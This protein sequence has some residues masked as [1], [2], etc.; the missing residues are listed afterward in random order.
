[1]KVYL[2]SNKYRNERIT[3]KLDNEAGFDEFMN[4]LHCLIRGLQHRTD[5]NNLY[6]Y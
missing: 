3:L 1:M 4:L 2:N 6:I 5:D